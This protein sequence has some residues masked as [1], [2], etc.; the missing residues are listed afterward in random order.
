MKQILI[1]QNIAYAAKFGGGT[2]VGINELNLLDTGALAFFTEENVLITVA[3]VNTVMDDVKKFKVAVGNQAAASK[4]YLSI[5]IPRIGSTYKISPYTA[6]VKLIKYLG[7]DG[8]VGSYNLPV[9]VAGQEFAIKIFDTTKGLRNM[10]TVYDNEENRYSTVVKTGD[11]AAT[12]T[13]RLVSI[14]NN[15][16]NSIVTALGIGGLGI[17]LTANNFGTTFEIILTGS[18]ILTSSTIEQPNAILPS[19]VGNSVNLDYGVGTYTEVA[20]LEELYS[21][22]RGNTNKIWL[23]QFYYTVPKLSQAGLT[24]DMRTIAFKG[25]RSNVLGRQDTYLFEVVIP[26]VVGAAQ[27]AAVATIIAGIYDFVANPVETGS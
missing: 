8:V 20:A 2:I 22:E 1:G 14:I 11:T 26:T 13:A 4:S 12:L 23:S 24:Y 9:L 25:D 7:F 19:V 18:G 16:S 3:N 17:E 21:P 10:A 15:N 5:D 27:D 6:P